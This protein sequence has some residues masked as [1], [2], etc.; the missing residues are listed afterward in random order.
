MLGNLYAIFGDVSV[1]F[2]EK[3]TQ[4]LRSTV[5]CII[6]LL[7]VELYAFI[8]NCVC[9][10]SSEIRLTGLPSRRLDTRDVPCHS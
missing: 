3:F 9:Q 10:P 4:I 8:M 7:I 5:N 6:C 1:P 2:G